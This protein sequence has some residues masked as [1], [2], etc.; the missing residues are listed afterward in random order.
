[1]LSLM[2]DG[3]QGMVSAE[4]NKASHWQ[5]DFDILLSSRTDSVQGIVANEK[6]HGISLAYPIQC[7]SIVDARQPKMHGS[8]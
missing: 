7:A 2:I 6:Y 3:Y 4:K 8:Q 5:D 1:V